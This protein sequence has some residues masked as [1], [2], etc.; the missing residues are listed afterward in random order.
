MVA[1]V[2]VVAEFVVVTGVVVLN[3]LSLSVCG[4]NPKYAQLLFRTVPS[5]AAV[6]A[7]AGLRAQ[8][9]LARHETVNRALK[10]RHIEVSALVAAARQPIHGASPDAHARRMHTPRL[11]LGTR[12]ECPVVLSLPAACIQIDQRLQLLDVCYARSH[13]HQLEPVQRVGALSVADAL[14]AGEPAEDPRS[15]AVSGAGSSPRTL[16]PA[17]AKRL[18][19]LVRS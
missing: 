7:A 3:D 17:A 12:L 13:L 11:T 8:R 19:L 5:A 9:R 4:M 1:A 15:L 10:R 2:I 18:G 6:A 14:K 16:S